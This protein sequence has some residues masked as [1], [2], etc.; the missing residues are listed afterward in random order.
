MKNLDDIEENKIK[1]TT[2]RKDMHVKK[3]YKTIY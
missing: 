3:I 2:N 1:I